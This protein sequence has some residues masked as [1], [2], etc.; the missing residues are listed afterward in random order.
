[1]VVVV[2]ERVV[3]IDPSCAVRVRLVAG[4]FMAEVMFMS[5]VV[6]VREREDE[7]MVAER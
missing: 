4:R 2:G 3:R 7:V 6:W 1:M 5:P